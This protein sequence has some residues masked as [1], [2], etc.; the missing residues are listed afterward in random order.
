MLAS[1]LHNAEGFHY[2]VATFLIIDYNHACMHSQFAGVSLVITS[3]MITSFIMLC[4]ATK[5][6]R[7]THL[8]LTIIAKN[9]YDSHERMCVRSS[10]GVHY[11]TDELKINA[12]QSP[13]DQLELGECRTTCVYRSTRSPS[14]LR[15]GSMQLC[16]T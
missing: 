15:Q 5:L 2:I 11:V 16:I 10:A 7:Y 1:Q 14:N 3:S 4:I 6:L 9:V 13:A 8:I 12:I